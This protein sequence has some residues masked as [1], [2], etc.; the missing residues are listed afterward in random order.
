VRYRVVRGAL[1]AFHMYTGDGI[2]FDPGRI[3][4]TLPQSR[5]S[6]LFGLGRRAG[7]ACGLR[8]HLHFH[9]RHG[10]GGGG[11]SAYA[12]PGHHPENDDHR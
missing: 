12:S 10:A 8:L 11:G 2:P 7:A 9:F 1:I 4:S 3:L 5:H 6:A